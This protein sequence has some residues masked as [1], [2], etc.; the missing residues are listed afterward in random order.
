MQNYTL[1]NTTTTYANKQKQKPT[2]LSSKR[3]P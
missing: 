3:S 1:K 2:N